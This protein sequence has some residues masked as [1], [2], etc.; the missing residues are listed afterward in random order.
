MPRVQVG[1]R[2]VEFP[3]GT[4]QEEMLAALAQLPSDPAPAHEPPPKETFGKYGPLSMLMR[5]QA[6]APQRREEF[7]QN[8]PVLGAGVV[9][10]L[11]GGAGVP[12]IPAALA[13]GGGGYLG[14][15]GRGDDQGSAVV[16]GI[17]QAGLHVGG[18][19]V[20]AG[21]QAL[22][23]PIYRSAVPKTVLDKFSR[24]DVAGS[25]LENRVVL[26][27]RGGTT[28]AVRASADA[29]AK[30]KAAAGSVK[31]MSAQDVQAAFRPKY[32]KALTGRNTQLASEIDGYV[33]GAMDEIG[34]TS[35]DGVEQL[36]RKEGLEQVG[37]S[38]MTAQ[39]SK[40][41]AVNPQLAN[42]ERKAVA[43]NLRTSPQMATALDRSQAAIGVNRAASAT[44]N[45]SLLNRL[46]G[47]GLWNA[48][49]SPMVQSGAAIGMN[50]LAQLPWAQLVRMAQI[51]SLGGE[52]E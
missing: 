26:G 50:E 15:V 32:N 18:A 35:M 29:G 37:K 6:E 5:D 8:L 2:V 30:V 41:A 28:R 19:A 16:E 17:K 12:L 33:K 14:A 3:D 25:G 27:T 52:Q 48:A 21:G 51:A 49:Q 22:A 9:A 24:A 43:Q 34:Q 44:E 47:G 40:L 4:P 42:I 7:K 11:T 46:R 31:P 20:S 36:A 38:A 10:A 45:S 1:S 39:N 13:V 23:R